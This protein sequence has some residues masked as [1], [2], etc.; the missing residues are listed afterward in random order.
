[1]KNNFF[2]MRIF[3]IISLV[4]TIILYTIDFIS[5]QS[6]TFYLD[7]GI[8]LLICDIVLELTLMQVFRLSIVYLG[9]T[10]I[11]SFMSNTKKKIALIINIVMVIIDIICVVPLIFVEMLLGVEGYEINN[12]WT[13]LV[14]F[15][16]LITLLIYNVIRKE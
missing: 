15:I 4:I 5:N 16:L 1:M 10:L 9:G 8:F 14:S 7:E 3:P 12:I 11:V 6:I 13:Y 2:K